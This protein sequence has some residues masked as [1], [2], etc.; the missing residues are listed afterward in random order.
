MDNIS[1]SITYVEDAA[2][3]IVKSIEKGPEVWKNAFNIAT[4]PGI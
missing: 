2:N 1:E 4:E 3:M